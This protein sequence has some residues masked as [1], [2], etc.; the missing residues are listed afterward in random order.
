MEI[1]KLNIQNCPIFNN[2][3][4]NCT[5]HCWT[6][7]KQFEIEL[8]ISNELFLNQF[9]IQ[10]VISNIAAKGL[11]LIYFSKDPGVKN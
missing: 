6:T 3:M 11:I 9:G 10:G 2:K 5:T 1:F 7:Q 4:C 8:P